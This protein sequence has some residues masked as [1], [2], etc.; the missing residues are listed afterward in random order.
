MYGF[1][2]FCNIIQ[3]DK[4]SILNMVCINIL[5]IHIKIYCYYYYY[6]QLLGVFV[7]IN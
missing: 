3:K 5:L 4:K 1:I 6:F 2:N 7:I